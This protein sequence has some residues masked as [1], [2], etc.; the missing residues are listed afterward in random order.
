MVYP[1]VQTFREFKAFYVDHTKRY[2]YTFMDAD[3]N[4][5]IVDKYDNGKVVCL[6]KFSMEALI[7]TMRLNI[8][9]DH[10]LMQIYNYVK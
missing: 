6:S 3:G 7:V 1:H 2:E 4:Q 9:D 10:Y 8:D 5:Q